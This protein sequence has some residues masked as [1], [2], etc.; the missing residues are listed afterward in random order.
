MRS[1]TVSY[2]DILSSKRFD[3]SY[4]NAEVNVYDNIIRQHSSHILS[5]YCSRIFTS[6]RNKRAYTTADYGIPFLSNSDAGI[7]DPFCS[8]NFTSRKYGYDE[9]GLLKGGMILTGRVGAIGQTAYVPE[10]WNDYNPIGSDNIIRIDVKPEFKSGFLY[11]FLAS[12]IGKLSFEKHSTGGVQPFITDDMVGSLP[13]PDFPE[14]LQ[15]KIDTLIKDTS[16]LKGQAKELHDKAYKLLIEYSGLGHLEIEEYDYFGP[17]SAERQGAI[18]SVNR[19]SIDST[20]INAF[21]HSSRIFKLKERIKSTVATRDLINCVDDKG[22]FSTG[23][24]PRKEVAP[25]YGIELI[26]QRDAFDSVI[27]GKSISRRG[28]KTDNLL[29]ENEIIIAGVGTLGEAETFCH[30]IYANKYLSGKL[31]SGEFIR[32]NSSIDMPSGYLFAWL[33]SPYGFRLIRNTQT[34]TKLCRPIPRLLA[35]LPVPVLSQ[36][37]MS[38]IN[39]IVLNAQS[40]LADASRKEIE[41]I[42]LIE[43]EIEKWN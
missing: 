31:I 37:K 14:L 6:G 34:G 26:N 4:H 39:Q 10:F 43:K 36:N 2:K 20:T 11:A 28:V 23:S 33:N 1:R 30:C 12:R 21:N 7:A 25:G 15:N 9:E 5:Y 27:R 24:F 40:C 18:F 35:H 13:I 38:E 42:S 16:I 8:C 3:G 17:R 29:K 41:A 22:F 32:M 19:K